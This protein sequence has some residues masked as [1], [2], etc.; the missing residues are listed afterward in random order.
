MPL[1]IPNSLPAADALSQENIFTMQEQKAITQDIR[2]LEIGVCNLMP[3]KIATET[4]LARML[5]NS[6]LQVKLTLIQMDS[7]ESRNVSKNHLDS[8]YLTLD[9]IRNRKFDGLIITGAPVEQLPFEKVDYWHELTELF[10]FSKN[11]VYSTVYICWGAQAGLYYHFGIKKH[12]LSEKL[13]GVFE[14]NVVRPFNP[15][16]RGFDE[17]FYAP[18]SRYTYVKKEDIEKAR[19]LRII[20]ESK[21][22]GPHIISTQKGKKIFVLGHMEYDKETLYNEYMRD[23]KAGLNPDIPKNYFKNDDPSSDILFRWR[24]HAN[25]FFHNWLNYYVYQK[26]PYNI[27]NVGNE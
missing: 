3:T 11:N 4:Q 18:H 15:L 22:A 24:S 6:P 17:C 19:E 23:V 12:E 1:I 8:F 13:V 9:E 5:A 26:T 7:H 21:E 2:P 10:E 20:A 16:A 25:L 27:M 14:H